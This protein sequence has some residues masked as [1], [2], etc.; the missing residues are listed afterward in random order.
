MLLFI[1]V[2][3]TGLPDFNKRASDP[4]QPHIVQLACSLTNDTGKVF[5]SHNVI[6]YPNGWIISQEMSDIHGITMEIAER[7]GIGESKVAELLMAMI[8]KSSLLVAHNLQFDKFMSRILMR[9][10]GFLS[11]EQDAW[12]KAL[13]SFCTMKSSTEICQLP[14][15]NGKFKWPKL[16]EAYQHFFNRELDN[17]HDALADVTACREI[18][19]KLK[20]AK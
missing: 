18:Y 12:W 20:E 14:G 13:P 2:E 5:E 16:S 9:R 7:Y 3:T 19:F 10:M 4:S 15:N 1:D 8:Q 11:D 17:S 6:V